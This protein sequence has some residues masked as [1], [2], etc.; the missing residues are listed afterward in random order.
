MSMTV[1]VTVDPPKLTMKVGPVASNAWVAFLGV[2]G[3][4]LRHVGRANGSGYYTVSFPTTVVPVDF[5]LAVYSLSNGTPS[6]EGTFIANPSYFDTPPMPTLGAPNLKVFPDRV[7]ILNGAGTL[8]DEVI[9]TSRP[10]V[11]AIRQAVSGDVIGVYGD[12]TTGN[13]EAM[14]LGGA[15]DANKYHHVH[16]GD[17]PM[18]FAVVGMT[19]DAKITGFAIAR[20][21]SYDG[22]PTA[23]IGDVMFSNL[24]MQN[25]RWSQMAIAGNKGV[26][27]GRLRL[28]NM[29]FEPHPARLAAGNDG[30]FGAK[31]WIRVPSWGSWD[32]RNCSFEGVQEHSI[33]IDSPQGDNFFDGIEHTRSWRTAIQIVNR[34]WELPNPPQGS[35]PAQS[36]AFWNDLIA[37]YESGAVQPAPSGQGR[38]LIRDVTMQGIYGEGGSGVTVVGFDGDVYL[39]NV[40]AVDDGPFH[41]AIV[42]LAMIPSY[43]LQRETAPKRGTA[44]AFSGDEKALKLC[45]GGIGEGAIDRRRP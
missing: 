25:S 38:I 1:D 33:Y 36:N 45:R 2:Q 39:E 21:I 5:E 22:T 42:L 27:F 41:G 15:Q 4:K 26:T 28:Y 43:F 20:G 35:T 23:G 8:D 11:E 6:F 44:A 12:C 34:A 30:G 40:T 24:T 3:N 32:V 7:E 9:F 37:E 16:W 17:E 31:W 10:L 14:W 29:H 18:H 19:P 13:A